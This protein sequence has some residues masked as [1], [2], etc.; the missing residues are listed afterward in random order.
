MSILP[1]GSQLDWLFH[2][3]GTQ[4]QPENV[5]EFLAGKGTFLEE[6]KT[7]DDSGEGRRWK[8]YEAKLKRG[9]N[10]KGEDEKAK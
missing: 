2:L 6:S 10:A 3:Q 7:R 9:R 5:H 1:S 4:V 8:N